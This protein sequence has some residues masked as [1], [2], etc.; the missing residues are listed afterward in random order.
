MH[1]LLV[2]NYGLSTK[3]HCFLIMAVLHR[4]STLE[5]NVFK[6]VSY[7]DRTMHACPFSWELRP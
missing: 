5:C 7:K 1:V 6:L 3:Q 2:E 4:V